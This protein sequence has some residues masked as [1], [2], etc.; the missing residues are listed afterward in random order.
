M[1]LKCH[2]RCKD[3]KEHRYWSIVESIRTRRGVMKR[4]ALYL[5]EINDAQ[6]AQWCSALDVFD[7]SSNS[8]RQMSLFP[9]DRTPPSEVTHAIQIRLNQ[10]IL[11]RPRQWG[12]CWLA[13]ELWNQLGLDA[14]WR[15]RLP[16]SSKGTDWLH[17][18]KTLVSY[19]LLDPGSEWRLHRDW[20]KTSAMGDLLG[21]DDSVAAKNTLYRC[22][23]K[24]CEHK[25]DLFC[26]LKE[27]W[28]QLFG[29]S[30]DVLLYDLTSTYF[31]C[32]PPEKAEGLR[33]FGYSRDKRPDCVQVVIALIVTPDGF[34]VAYEVMPGN[35]SDKTTLP[36]FLRKI[37]A[38]YGAM[39]RL[40]IMDRGIPTEGTLEQMR[41]EGA[42][43]L[44]GTPRGRLS[45]LESQLSTQS[46]NKVQSQ[47]E[48]KLA[49]DRED[50][51]VLTRSGGRR[52][53]EQSMR[54]RRLNKLWKRLHQIRRMKTLKRDALLLKLGAAKKEAGK[55]WGLVNIRLPEPRQPVTPESFT[56]GLNREK[57]RRVRRAE[58]TYLLRTNLT[59]GK[60]DELW[61]Q[62]IILTEIE[63]AFKEIKQDLSIRPIYHQKDER[64][65]AHIFV[66][67]LSYC[68][69]VTLKHK[70]RSK[71]PGLTPR[72]IVEKFKAMQMIDV[73]LPTTDGRQLILP[74][75]T[76]PEK[77]IQLLLCQL[78][79]TLPKQPSPRIEELKTKCGA[80][81]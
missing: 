77:D 18:L 45:K 57:L 64:I 72:A 17:V 80:D 58:G 35:T 63:Q 19:R 22:L 38:Q 30:Y 6:R 69:Q 36:E 55:A 73:H 5:G 37:E 60:P 71:A 68:L 75:Y 47:V 49:R 48:V 67:F 8:V 39:N 53:K 70:A 34:P 24:L 62:Y 21:E 15:R 12:G 29:I 10:M 66:S 7:N 11:R 23:D 74:R 32:D 51:Y 42:S 4:Q 76:Q 33:R 44:V 1:Y 3:G 2:K 59:E 9:E 56:F 79:L 28:S 27:R 25:Q 13:M 41:T 31:E 26:F 14:F 65:E 61:K 81:L 43:Y 46:W 50:L 16:T 40:W 20:F 52:D 78:N 54:R